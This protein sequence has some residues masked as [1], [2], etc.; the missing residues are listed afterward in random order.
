MSRIRAN[1]ITNQSA[2]G[3]PTVQNGLVISGVTTST[4]FS[5]SGANLTNIPSA[6]LTGAL[7]AISGANLT[8]ID[9]TIVKDSGGNTRVSGTLTG[10]VVSGILTATSFMEVKGSGNAYLNLLSTGTGLAGIYMDAS[11]GDISGSDYCSIYQK[12]DLNLHITNRKNTANIIFE[13]GGENERL[14]ISSSGA[15]M[16]NTTNS[17]SR[18]LNLN[19]TFGILSTNQSGVI[20]MSVTDAGEASIGPYVAGG[21]T[22]ILKTNGSGSGVAERL[23][24]TSGG[25][26]GVNQSNPDAYH[27]SGQNLVIGTSGEEGMTIVS[28][29]SSNGVIN[30]ADGTGSASYIGRIIYAHS[31]NSMRFNANGAERF[32]IGSDGKLYTGG[33][34]FYPLVNYTEVTTFSNAAV[35]SSSY[36][37]LRTI[38]SGYTPKKA[39]NRIVIHHQSQM[40]NGAAAS[41]NGDVYWK[42]QRQEGGGSWTDTVKNERILGNHDGHSYTGGSGLARHHRT[43]HLMGSFICAGTS[44]NLKTQGR[45][46]GISWDWYHDGNNVLQIWEY[47]I[48]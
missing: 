1:Q 24:I 4:T 31:D 25:N 39:G 28:G 34:Q 5:G 33:T 11:D 14:R 3:A 45:S 21:S 29:S 13:S 43:V 48:S 47:D 12:N 27:S 10:A 26:V 32:R 37:D 19:G 42:I 41:A 44:I 23:R 16:I 46:V 2:D 36:T 30:F 9:A 40:W 17:S 15:V 8:G 22:L 18:T 20:D 6:Q 38:L 35:S 7:P